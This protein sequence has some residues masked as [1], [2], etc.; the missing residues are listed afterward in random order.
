MKRYRIRYR[1]GDPGCPTFTWTTRASS[2]EHALE[3]FREG[4]DGEGWLIL[5]IERVDDAGRRI[6]RRTELNTST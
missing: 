3:L 2:R 5:T 1:D 6:G 4:P